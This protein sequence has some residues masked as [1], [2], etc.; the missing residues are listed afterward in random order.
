MIGSSYL[1]KQ[2]IQEYSNF[3]GDK[4]ARIL[5]LQLLWE[6]EKIGWT[7]CLS[8]V[9]EKNTFSFLFIVVVIFKGTGL[10]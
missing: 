8:Q 9:P 10:N 7:E 2:N 4:A 1:M 3:L 5:E 6:K